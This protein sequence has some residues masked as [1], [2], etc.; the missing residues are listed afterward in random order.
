MH[1]AMP[2]PALLGLLAAATT[3][4]GCT[5]DAAQD[6]PAET[7]VRAV[8]SA[9]FGT[10]PTGESV[11]VFTLA[12]GDGMEVR[13]LDYG[14][15]IQSIRVPDRDGRIV[16]V[17]LGYDDL[18]G[19][20]SDTY[21][22]GAVAGRYANRIANG[23][24]TIDSTTYQLARNNG[25]NHLHGG[26][27]GFDKVR[28]HAEPFQRGDSV[29][30]TLHYTSPAG[31]EGYPGTLEV[32]V[33]YVVTMSNE[34]VVAYHAT[35]DAPTHVN[36]TQHTYFNLAGQGDIL[37]HGLSIDA[38]R[39][40]P[41]DSTAIPLAELA[42]VEGTPFDFRA[43]TPV[44]SRIGVD[45]PQ[46]A[47]G[48]G[49]NHNYVLDRMDDDLTHA[50]RLVDPITGRTLDVYTTAPGVQLYTGNRLSGNVVGKGGVP[51]ERRAGLYLETQYYPNSPNRPDFP[52]TLLRPGDS[53]DSRTVFSFGVVD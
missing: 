32:Q 31:E 5:A 35:T 24:F 4:A 38:S 42:N 50:A 11:T 19:Y 41:I 53:Y 6:D 39:Y 17:T 48:D 43:L 10:L 1:S 13:V 26:E 28:W 15:T 29:G 47:L 51:L 27:R 40:T 8:E 52:S 18:G 33:T 20:L 44:G 3:A 22:M 9:P 45:H 30:V 14:A 49:Y 34:L 37:D 7:A 25:P 12:N 23:Q 16:D 21:Y 2:K 36:L 46:L